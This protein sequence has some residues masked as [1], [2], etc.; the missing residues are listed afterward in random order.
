MVP[1]RLDH[2]PGYFMC[3][4]HSVP[5]WVQPSPVLVCVCVCVFGV[6]VT[7]CVR[8]HASMCVRVHASMHGNVL[9]DVSR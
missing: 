6:G 7:V 5:C 8:M 9:Y 2:V 1:T 3:L 4:C